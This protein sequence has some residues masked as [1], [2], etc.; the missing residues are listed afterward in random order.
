MRFLTA[1]SCVIFLPSILYWLNPFA[2][3]IAR[4]IDIFRPKT[5][6][7]KAY[8]VGLLRDILLISPRFGLLGLS[9]AIA[10]MS[11]NKIVRYFSIEG[12]MGVPIVFC[13]VSLE[14]LF[15]AILCFVF[16]SSPN[17]VSLQQAIVYVVY[18]CL[19]ASAYLSITSLC[20][21]FFGQ[22]SAS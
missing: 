21:R 6:L 5:A 19:Y 17:E 13:F 4:D 1:S 9:S 15:D 2:V 10:C 22:R 16:V 18:S 14:A 11:T 8:I 20:K 3:S 12:M 7:I